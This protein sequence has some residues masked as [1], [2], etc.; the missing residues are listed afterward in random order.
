MFYWMIHCFSFFSKQLWV[1]D[2]RESPL[3]FTI[4]RLT[5]ASSG[6][7]DLIPL[8][9]CVYVHMQMWDYCCTVMCSRCGEES[10][11]EHSESEPPNRAVT[12]RKHTHIHTHTDWLP[13][14][15]H[16]IKHTVKKKKTAQK[17]SSQ[18]TQILPPTVKPET[19]FTAKIHGAH[20][21]H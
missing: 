21:P 16:Q 8:L 9:G 3:I 11:S 18:H 5:G 10:E 1:T 6:V 13:A 12:W 2:S 19:S 15:Q 14:R 20:L 7:I 17:Q 4:S